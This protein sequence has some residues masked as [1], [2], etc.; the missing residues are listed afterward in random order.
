MTGAGTVRADNP[1]LNVRWDYGAWIRQPRRV[2][3][4]PRLSLPPSAQVFA[5]P[6]AI[7]FAAAD[8]AGS[9]P[10]GVQL[11]RVARA[12]EGL[13]L[14]AIMLRLAALEV[15]EL[16]VECGARLAESLLT[17]Q[18]VDEFIV[19]L[20]P[21]LLGSDARPL[22]ELSG[23]DSIRD[24]PR[25]EFQDVQRIGADVRLTLIPRH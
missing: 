12:A 19:Y 18:L 8:A 17:A 1:R 14:P 13:D 20:A 21:A 16:L 11:E 4:D 10:P 9:A 2:I 7:V 22:T 24:A 3:L 6:G 5:A 23:L 25:F 15:N